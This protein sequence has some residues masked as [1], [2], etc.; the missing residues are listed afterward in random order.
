M[1]KYVYERSNDVAKSSFFWFW[2]WGDSRYRY[3]DLLDDSKHI[4]QCS[5]HNTESDGIFEQDSD[6]EPQSDLMNNI[7]KTLYI[8]KCCF[9]A[10]Y[11]KKQHV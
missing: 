1:L 7:I 11:V 5:Y 2:R 9:T 10:K 4:K 8:N 3:N 6:T